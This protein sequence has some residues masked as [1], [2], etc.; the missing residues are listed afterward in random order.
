M[1]H[2]LG[3]PFTDIPFTAAIADKTS[4]T[5]SGLLPR[6]KIDLLSARVK[7]CKCT[8]IYTASAMCFFLAAKNT[9]RFMNDA[10]IFR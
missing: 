6:W 7:N 9:F 1:Y 8:I 2:P 5:S 10:L 4:R 3:L